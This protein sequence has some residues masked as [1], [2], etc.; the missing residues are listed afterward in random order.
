MEPGGDRW[1]GVGGSGLLPAP[2]AVIWEL[3]TEGRGPMRGFRAD[4]VIYVR[5]VAAQCYPPLLGR[6]GQKNFVKI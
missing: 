5:E 2:Q 3:R 4:L 6:M 1:C